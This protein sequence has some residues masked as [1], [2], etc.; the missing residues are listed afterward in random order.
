MLRPVVVLDV[1]FTLCNVAI[2]IVAI[3]FNDVLLY[4]ALHFPYGVIA[5]CMY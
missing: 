5:A 1:V 3:T 2:A 4:V